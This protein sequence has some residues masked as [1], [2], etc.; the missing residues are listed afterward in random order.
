MDGSSIPAENTACET[1]A[2]IGHNSTWNS[3]LAAG[4][5]DTGLFER[6]GKLLQ[7]ANVVVQKLS[8]TSQREMSRAS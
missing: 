4:N 3:Q 7:V 6:D 2:R 8:E 1:V 5:F